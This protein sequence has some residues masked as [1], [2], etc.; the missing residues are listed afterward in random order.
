QDEPLWQDSRHPGQGRHARRH[1]PLPRPRQGPPP[2]HG[3]VDLLPVHRRRRHFSR[4]RP[5]R[6]PHGQD[7][8]AR[9]RHHHGLRRRPHHGPGC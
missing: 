3:H 4:R 5:A 8:P 1:L 2:L 9:L 7:L 6:R